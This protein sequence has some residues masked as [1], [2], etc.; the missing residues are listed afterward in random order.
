MDP[1]VVSATIILTLLV[2]AG[3]L[4]YRRNRPLFF[5][6]SLFFIGLIPV[7]HIIPLPTLMNDR[8]LYYPL[9]GASVFLAI[10]MHQLY[11]NYRMIAAVPFCLALL[12]LPPL[13]WLRTDVWRN[14]ISLWEDVARKEPGMP[15]AWAS[16]G[17]SYYDAGQIEKA[18][19]S[20]LR[21]LAIDPNYQLAMNNI[22]GL[23]N[24]LGER[25]KARP[26]LVRV[27]K[28]F[29]DDVKGYMNLG[30]NYYGSGE[31]DKAEEMYRKALELEPNLP[32][33][34]YSL[35]KVLNRHE[36]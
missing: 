1:A 11:K 26:Y 6:Y 25:E 7:A 3:Y 17:M 33:A 12:F 22:G 32:S 8:Y 16:L 27:V 14:D 15:L 20:Y 31:F 18:L 10:I 30:N 28:F 9:V 23:Y 35:E 21:A 5:W 4:L 24:E 2:T 19:Q 29:P 36:K 13:S 34:L